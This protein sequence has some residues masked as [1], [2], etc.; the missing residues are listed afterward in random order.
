MSGETHKPFDV[1]GWRGRVRAGWVDR[2][3]EDPLALIRKHPHHVLRD[4]PISTVHMVSLDGEYIFIKHITGRKDI[5]SG[6]RH[7]W[8]QLLYRVR[9]SPAL[10]TLRISQLC[11]NR[12]VQVPL[13]LLAARRRQAGKTEDLLIT[14]AVRGQTVRACI[15]DAPTAAERLRV[16][17]HIT[18]ALVE[19]HRAGLV[20]GDMLP[21]NMIVRDADRAVVFLDN[22]R[23]HRGRT[24]RAR[25]RNV[26][27]MVYR[28]LCFQ[29]YGCAVT[30]HFMT[31]Y[32]Q[33]M[34]IGEQ[35]ARRWRLRIMRR[36]RDRFERVF[37]GR[38]TFW[39]G[40]KREDLRGPAP[41]YDLDAS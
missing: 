15:Y 40:I 33:R 32:M 29:D 11:L 35:A 12:G 14:Q 10:R 34:G 7:L 16:V 20:H 21:G 4:R 2:F 36:C 26:E 13:V 22:E 24:R 38:V 17:E 5:A 9:P 37:G 18:E 6:L 27:Q 31:T 30:R 1:A 8:H 41:Q 25:M 39:A 28:L 23:T 3:D 19:L